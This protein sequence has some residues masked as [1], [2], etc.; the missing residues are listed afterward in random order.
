MP[1][2][3]PEVL[4]LIRVRL[5]P[6]YL[7][8]V[9]G[10]YIARSVRAEETLSTR[11]VCLSAKERGGYTGNYEDLVAH[12][13][14]Y[15]NECEHLWKDGFAIEN[16]LFVVR[17][18][19]SGTFNSPD[20]LIDGLKHRIGFAFSILARLQELADEMK[21]YVEGIYV[22]DAGIYEV[23]DVI[24][25][26][27]NSIITAGGMIVLSGRNFKVSGAEDQPLIGVFLD[28]DEGDHSR[29]EA[30]S[31]AENTPGKI[32]LQ[33]PNLGAGIYH[34]RIVTQWTNGGTPLKEP[35]TIFFEPALTIL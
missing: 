8:D 9:E 32:I 28:D 34:L 19:V 25:Q 10:L 20:E 17:P 33:L 3:P 12:V 27:K 24:S 31:L 11:Q 26:A 15:L 14:V 6:N 13:E 1:H 18:T 2:L 5:Y 16:G 21:I 7:P 23:L 35:R 4:H 30:K 29:I 22:A